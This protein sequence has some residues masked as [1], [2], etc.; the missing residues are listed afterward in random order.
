MES[1]IARPAKRG[2]ASL[3]YLHCGDVLCQRT[4]SLPGPRHSAS[5]V[6]T[7]HL[8]KMVAVTP[9]GIL[10]PSEQ[11]RRSARAFDAPCACIAAIGVWTAPGRPGQVA[12]FEPFS[13]GFRCLRMRTFSAIQL[14]T[15]VA[16]ISP[17]D[18]GC[19]CATSH[20]KLTRTTAMVTK[21]MIT[22]HRFALV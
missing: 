11:H 3:H 22:S 21:P 7:L 9:I 5:R 10:P 1:G 2:W 15:R 14:R 19:S 17:A 20:K 13:T 12:G 16:P 4:E 8:G 6:L 18:Q